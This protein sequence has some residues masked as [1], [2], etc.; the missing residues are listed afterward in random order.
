MWVPLVRQMGLRYCQVSVASG[1]FQHAVEP[2]MSQLGGCLDRHLGPAAAH[3]HNARWAARTPRGEEEREANVWTNTH[4]R[5]VGASVVGNSDG[6][7]GEMDTALAGCPGRPLEYGPG[8][9]WAGVWG[10]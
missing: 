4:R 8:Q 1:S 9:T 6:L 7:R 5:S 3:L 10:L 2:N